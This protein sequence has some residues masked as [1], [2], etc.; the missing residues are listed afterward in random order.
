MRKK[1]F[2]ALNKDG[3][4][5]T[6]H[7]VATFDLNGRYYVFYTDMQNMYVGYYETKKIPW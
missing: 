7:I 6:C 4:N 3:A 2:E 5:V 1:V